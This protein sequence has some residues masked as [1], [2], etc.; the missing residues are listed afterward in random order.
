M[1]YKWFLSSV[2]TTSMIVLSACVKENAKTFT[3]LSSVQDLVVIKG[4]GISNFK[5]SNI[6][7]AVPEDTINIDLW[8]DLAGINS[9][10]ADIPVKIAVDDAKRVAYN[11]TNGTNF[12]AAT[13]NQYKIA[14]TTLTIP[15]GQHFAKTTV[16]VFKQTIDPTKSWM[17]PISIMDASGKALSSNQNTLYLNIIGNP[18]A[19]NYFWDFTRWNANDSTGTPNSLSFTGHTTTFVPVNST[20]IEVASGYFIGPRYQLSFT[21]NGGVL[22]N[23]SVKFNDDDV[24]AMA[25]GGVTVTSSPVILIAN[26]VTKVFRFQFAVVTSSGP[27]YIIDKYYK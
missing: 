10:T 9:A 26:P 12:Q 3:D 24:K 5:A 19:G 22:S 11:S 6:S 8:V 2:L 20:M 21:D 27:R 14:N 23:F 25:D 1:N 4:S 17:L 7:L 15:K 18:L 16:Q 13:A